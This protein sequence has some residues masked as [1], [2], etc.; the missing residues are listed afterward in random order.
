MHRKYFITEKERRTSD[1]F[2]FQKGSYQG[3]FWKEDSL[4]LSADYFDE[5]NLRKF[6]SK[7]LSHFSYYG[8]TE[9]GRNDWKK[10]EEEA[11]KEGGE[12]EKLIKEL[13]PWVKDCFEKEEF[14]TILGL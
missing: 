11:K 14:F 2:E 4:L 6:F 10:I 13:D 5:F 7:L 12:I 8:V 3:E 1:Y 9:I